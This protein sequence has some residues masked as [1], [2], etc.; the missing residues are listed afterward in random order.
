MYD[1][2]SVIKKILR[3]INITTPKKIKQEEISDIL[4]KNKNKV[5]ELFDEKEIDDLADEQ[6]NIHP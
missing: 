2:L 5:I 6:L 4:I 1:D 3:K